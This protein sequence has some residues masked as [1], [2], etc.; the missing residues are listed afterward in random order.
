[1]NDE[2]EGQNSGILDGCGKDV[3]ESKIDRFRSED[4]Y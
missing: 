4:L 2:S 3:D 1:M